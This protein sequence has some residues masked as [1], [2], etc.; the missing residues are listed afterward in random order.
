MADLRA[1]QPINLVVMPNSQY[2]IQAKTEAGTPAGT[3][4]LERVMNEY[5]FEQFRLNDISGR[6]EKAK[7]Q[8]NRPV[9]LVFVVDRAKPSY[10]KAFPSLRVNLAIAGIVSLAFSVFFFM[11][12]E[13]VTSLRKH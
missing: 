3:T 13:R 12:R 6:Y 11:F 5:I 4:Q 2:V 1:K 10:R 8:Y 9:T 7:T